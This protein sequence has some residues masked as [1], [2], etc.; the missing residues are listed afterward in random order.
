M[1]LGATTTGCGVGAGAPDSWNYVNADGVAFAHPKDW[2]NLPSSALPHGALAG[3][4]WKQ[5]GKEI[6]TVEVLPAPGKGW[7]ARPKG[8]K[9]KRSPAF[10]LGDKPADQVTYTYRHGKHGP[11]TRVVYLRVVDARDRPVLIRIQGE[12]PDFTQGMADMIADSVQVGTVG[13]GNIV[14]T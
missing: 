5:D 2:T 8:A 7:P 12:G 6:A 10:T 9:V 13:K 11:S 14:K 1:L 4:V 3:A